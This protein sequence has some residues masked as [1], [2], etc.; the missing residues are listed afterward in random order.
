MHPNISHIISFYTGWKFRNPAMAKTKSKEPAE[1]PF[2]TCCCFSSGPMNRHEPSDS[3][4][5]LKS[6]GRSSSASFFLVFL[7][8]VACPRNG[9]L[10]NVSILGRRR[11]R[12]GGRWPFSDRVPIQAWKPHRPSMGLCYLMKRTY[13]LM[14]SNIYKYSIHGWSGK[15]P[16]LLREA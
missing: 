1:Q 6:H 12:G 4:A 16:L 5:F 8:P 7:R 15:D 2:R 14:I 13:P 10:R 11:Q 9:T 3:V